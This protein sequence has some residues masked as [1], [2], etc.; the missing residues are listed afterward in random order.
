MWEVGEKDSSQEKHPGFCIGQLIED[1]T[2][3]PEIAIP[4]GET[5]LGTGHSVSF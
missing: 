1:V 3:F 4:G 5:G 2:M